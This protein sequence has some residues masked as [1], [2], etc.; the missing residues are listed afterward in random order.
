VRSAPVDDDDDDL[1]L[2]CRRLSL[3]VLITGGDRV[4]IRPFLSR[5]TGA[6]W[7]TAAPLLL[8]LLFAVG[9]PT[10]LM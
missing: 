2:S 4:E 10:M 7:K 9:G 1:S 6:L 5:S 8:L 3:L